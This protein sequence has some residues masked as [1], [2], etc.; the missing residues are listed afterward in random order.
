M[1][2]RYDRSFVSQFTRRTRDDCGVEQVRH[3][4]GVR[5]HAHLPRVMFSARLPVAVRRRGCVMLSPVVVAL[6]TPMH[7]RRCLSDTLHVLVRA[8]VQHHVRK[9]AVAWILAAE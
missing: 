6:D 8:R 2:Q 1:R 3:T 5:V 4:R 7:L 9:V